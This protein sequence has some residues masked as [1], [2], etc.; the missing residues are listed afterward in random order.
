MSR[1]TLHLV[2]LVAVW[3]A[4]AASTS[5]QQ[6][7]G[8]ALEADP[9]LELAP[10]GPGAGGSTSSSVLTG[11]TSGFDDFNRADGPLGTDWGSGNGGP[12]EIRGQQFANLGS[13]NGW[14]L[15]NGATS[16]YDQ[17]VIE[18]TLA[19]NPPSLAYGA[20][21]FGAGGTDNTFTKIQGSGSY[22]NIGF[23]H[24]N[25]SS[26]S[27]Y[28]GYFT[29]TPVTGGRVRVYVTDAGDTMNCDIDEADDGVFEYHYES[30]GLISSG[31]AAQLGEGLGLG[32]YA[33]VS[34]IDDFSANGGG[35]EPVLQVMDL[36]PGQF[37]TIDIS[38]LSEGS[39]AL[40]LLSSIGPGPT[41]TPYGEFAVSQPWRRTPLFPEVDGVV[42]FTST[43]PPGSIGVT[44]YMQAAEWLVDDTIL[45]TNPIALPLQ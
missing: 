15:Y 42:N 27:G 10:P 30:S 9:A 25:G 18:F 26:M 23:Y 28:G 33:G 20:A 12:F 41:V 37:M 21:I 35:A 34:R 43:L 44:F 1:C 31:L 4:C 22:T 13:G 3:A 5:A 6:G 38:N 14:A 11:A 29:I 45:I 16:L 7:F 32:A 40:L 19:P 8:P 2:S 39:Q 17:A 24:G 36:V